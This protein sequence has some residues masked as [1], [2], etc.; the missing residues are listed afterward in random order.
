MVIAILSCRYGKRDYEVDDDDFLDE[1]KRIF[2][3]GKRGDDEEKRRIF[4][5][6]KRDGDLEKRPVFRYGKRSD[7]DDLLEE[8]KR[9]IMRY[10]REARSP[11][12]PHQPFRFGEEEE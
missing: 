11:Q 1:D 2:R 6:G 7:L 10:G 9:R 5:Y 12:D 4:R 3:Y 8:A